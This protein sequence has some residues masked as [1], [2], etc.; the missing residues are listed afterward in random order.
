LLKIPSARFVRLNEK[1]FLIGFLSAEWVAK[2][3]RLR[4]DKERPP[5]ISAGK[6]VEIS[7]RIAVYFANDFPDS[8]PAS[9]QIC[10]NANVNLICLFHSVVLFCC[11]LGVIATRSGLA[12]RKASVGC[13]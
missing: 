8:F 13:H 2:V 3:A 6:S 9:E 5:F 12:L 1:A 10:S 4:M 7:D 11:G